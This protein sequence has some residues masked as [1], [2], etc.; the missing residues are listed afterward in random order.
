T[1]NQPIPTP[2]YE[3]PGIDFISEN[4]VPLK[5][6]DNRAVA[7]N[8]SPQRLVPTDELIGRGQQLRVQAQAPPAVI[9]AGLP[10]PV[11]P[12]PVVSPLPASS[13]TAPLTFS[14]PVVGPTVT[15]P[16][17]AAGQPFLGQPVPGQPVPGQPLVGQPIVGQPIPSPPPALPATG[18]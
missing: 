12:P 5:I 10:Q 1:V 14:P 17:P 18:F 6:R 13:P 3:T 2:W 15:Q 9:P 7:F 4:L 16:P 11:G 8:L